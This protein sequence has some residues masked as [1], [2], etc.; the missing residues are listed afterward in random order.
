MISGTKS[1][2]AAR[3]LFTDRYRPFYNDENRV[4]QPRTADRGDPA[5]FE[6]APYQAGVI[7]IWRMGVWF[8]GRG[9]GAGTAAT[10]GNKMASVTQW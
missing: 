7:I 8:P 2:I 4:S 9:K 5:V 3:H 1:A 10:A 6:L